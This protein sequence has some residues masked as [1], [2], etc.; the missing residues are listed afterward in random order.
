MTDPLLSHLIG[1]ANDTGRPLGEVLRH[2]FLEGILRRLGGTDAFA[3]AGS[4]LTRVWSGAFPRAA[5]DVDFLGTFPHDVAE[6]TRRFVPPLA[7]DHDDGIRIDITRGFSKGIWQDTAF[8]GV[9]LSVIGKLF[10]Q[11]QATTVDIGFNDP[12]VP[13]AERIAY[14]PVWGD[15]VPVFA[16]HRATLAAWKLHGL[17]EWGDHNWRAK[18]V[19]D[20]WLLTVEPLPADEMTDAIRAAFVSRGYAVADAARVL[21]DAARWGDAAA[22]AKWAALFRECQPDPV[23]V[24]LTDAIADIRR[25]LAGCLRPHPPSPSP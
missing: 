2:H 13:P 16:V 15:P 11:R 1:V 18:D 22:Q 19:L 21:A 20:L 10:S 6:T 3:L 17:A 12:L 9:R 5:A 7:A 8:P 23:P 4:M 24:M 14:P 25:R